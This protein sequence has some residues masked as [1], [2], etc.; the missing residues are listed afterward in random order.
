MTN[1]KTQKGLSNTSAGTA[2][3]LSIPQPSPVFEWEVNNG[4]TIRVYHLLKNVATIVFDDGVRSQVYGTR[5]LQGNPE[6]DAISLV[7]DAA[8][9]YHTTSPREDPFIQLL[10]EPKAM[11]KLAKIL[12]KVWGGE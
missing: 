12:Q 1:L 9:H 4:G 3:S 10:E 2:K 6:L 8:N 7:F 11:K 5:E